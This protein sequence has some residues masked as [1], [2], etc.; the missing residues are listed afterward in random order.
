[1]RI[2]RKNKSKKSFLIFV[3]NITRSNFCFLALYFIKSRI[4]LIFILSF[5]FRRYLTFQFSLL[6]N[7]KYCTNTSK[8]FFFHFLYIK[9]IIIKFSSSFY[10]NDKIQISFHNVFLKQ[11]IIRVSRIFSLIIKKN[12]KIFIRWWLS[13][14]FI[15]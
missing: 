12:L 15:V 7:W 4:F 3:I 6:L 9:K 10:S 11:L 1:M 13:R 14:F 8:N 5:T 2:E